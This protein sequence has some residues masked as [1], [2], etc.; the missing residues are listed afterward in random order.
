MKLI[1]CGVHRCQQ[2]DGANARKIRHRTV[3]KFKVKP[4]S[5]LHDLFQFPS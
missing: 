4:E 1:P 3:V 2:Q 5:Q